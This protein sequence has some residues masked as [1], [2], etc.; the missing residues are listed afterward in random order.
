MYIFAGSTAIFFPF[1][2]ERDFFIVLIREGGRR[3]F[4]WRFF[5]SRKCKNHLE[6]GQLCYDANKMLEDEIFVIPAV[7]MNDVRCCFKSN[8]YHFEPNQSRPKIHFKQPIKPLGAF[9]PSNHIVGYIASGPITKQP[10]RGHQQQL[11]VTA[12][13]LQ[14]PKQ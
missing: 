7:A 2:M 1:V 8:P 3:R 14:K 10:S 11:A 13:L 9:L 4:H 5:F 12:P 6:H